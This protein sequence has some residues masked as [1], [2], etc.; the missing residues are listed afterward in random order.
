MTY[1]PCLC[2][3]IRALT[4]SN[5]IFKY[6][7]FKGVSWRR[8]YPL[9]YTA[10]ASNCRCYQ[11]VSYKRMQDDNAVVDSDS[12]NSSSSSSIE[13]YLHTYM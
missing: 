7:V 12:S 9:M 3:K 5:I 2:T 10:D 13:P 4:T 11:T 1:I 8:V 6:V